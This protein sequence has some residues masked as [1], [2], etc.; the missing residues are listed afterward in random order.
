MWPRRARSAAGAA[1]SVKDLMTP[2]LVVP[3]AMSA[4]T[5]LENFKQSG[6][7]VALIAD[8][9]GGLTGLVSLHDI[10]EAIIGELPSRDERARPRAVRRDDGSWLVDGMLD[11]D[12]FE[13]AVTGFKLHP[14][15][16][17]DYQ[18]FAGFVVRQLGHVP[19]EGETFSLHGY[20]VEV[21]DMDGHRV[22]KVLLMPAKPVAPASPAS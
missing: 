15:A 12:E 13:R 1:A 5:L 18:T 7:H 14:P 10:M 20:V 17:R 3:A 9:F 21:I 4:T 2:A 19:A 6:K 16:L 11:A 8:E 22:D